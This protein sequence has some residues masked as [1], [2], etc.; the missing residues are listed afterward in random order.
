MKTGQ[1]YL[2]RNYKPNKIQVGITPILSIWHIKQLR[3]DITSFTSSAFI[4]KK[5]SKSLSW[6][7]LLYNVF[8]DMEWVFIMAQ[9]FCPFLKRKGF[10]NMYGW[11]KW[12]DIIEVAVEPWFSGSRGSLCAAPFSCFSTSFAAGTPPP[13]TPLDRFN[14]ICLQPTRKEPIKFD[15]C[16]YL[17]Q[18]FSF[19]KTLFE[20]GCV[21]FEACK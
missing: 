2:F 10:L 5:V 6:L 17:W 18:G 8:L 7:M 20:V 21:K 4:L 16:V 13:L 15:S 12:C 19:L 9:Y 14:L 11:T 1:I 3:I